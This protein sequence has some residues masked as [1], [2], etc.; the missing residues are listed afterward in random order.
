MLGRA[1]NFLSLKLDAGAGGV[2]G[3]QTVLEALDLD[4]GVGEV[5]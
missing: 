4:D 3:V 2:A 1:S 5:E